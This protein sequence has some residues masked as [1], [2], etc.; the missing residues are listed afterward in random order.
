M[1]SPP[2]VP[3]PPSLTS[4]ND[5]YFAPQIC[6]DT[7]LQPPELD[8]CT[9]YRSQQSRLYPRPIHMSSNG[10]V[11]LSN[12]LPAESSAPLPIPRPAT[13]APPAMSPRT[14]QSTLATNNDIDAAL[15]RTIANGHLPMMANGETDTAMQFHHCTEQIKGLQDRILKYEDTFEWAPEGYI[16]NDSRVPHFRIPCGHGLSRPAK[17]IKLNDDGMVSGFA[18]TDGPKSTPH[19][20][21]LYAQADDQYT[22]EGDV[23]PA[24]PLPPWF[25][26]LLVGPSVD[27][28]LL[29]NALVDHDDWGL[30]CE[31]HRYHDLDCEF[32]DA[33]VKL[34][35]MQVDLNTI[36]QA[37]AA[38]ETRLLLAR[39]SE[40]VDKLE[41]V[42]RKAQATHSVW[43]HKTS[44]RG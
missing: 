26:F 42:P 9:I 22:E 8:L 7:T 36:S 35:Q 1:E 23:R 40:Q 31:V 3:S 14:I 38:S 4:S 41:N 30:T 6:T 24:L 32:S 39:A 37:C 34:E 10:S 25:R 16:L 13:P 33:C 27:F 21:D 28:A 17:W 11:N 12:V 20:A 29:H 5:S 2:F 15:L 44:G 43:K 18:D 19:V